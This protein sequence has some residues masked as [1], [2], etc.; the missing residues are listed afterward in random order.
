MDVWSAII[1]NFIGVLV[2]VAV[3]LGSMWLYIKAR[4]RYSSTKYAVE[5]TTVGLAIS[6]SVIF[7]IIIL[8]LS[9]DSYELG[10][11]IAMFFHAMYSGLGGL[12]FEGLDGLS[13]IGY[14]WLQ[15]CYTG[16]SIYASLMF[17]SVVT[18]TA[19]YE[20]YGAFLLSSIRFRLLGT[21]LNVCKKKLDLYVFTSATEDCVI[22]ASSIV[23]EYR[24]DPDKRANKI[25]KIIFAGDELESFDRK[26]PVHREIM[27]KG[28]IYM[29]YPKKCC[30]SFLT[31]LR[32]NIVNDYSDKEARVHLFAFSTDDSQEECGL[33]AK[34]ADII[35]DEIRALT[36]ECLLGKTTP[37][38]DFYVL[39]S[40]SEINYQ[41]YDRK[42]KEDIQKIVDCNSTIDVDIYSQHFQMHVVNEA[43]LA[44]ECLSRERINAYTS[45]LLIEDNDPS[46]NS[47]NGVT[48]TTD[49]NLYRAIVLGFGKTGQQALKTIFHDTSYV[50][51]KGIP[52]QFV[53]DVYDTNADALAGLFAINHPLFVCA[54]CDSAQ[55]IAFSSYDK[56]PDNP[57]IVA[58]YN[59]LEQYYAPLLADKDTTFLEVAKKL[60][61]PVVGFHQESCFA[62][63]F[64]NYLD[65]H[66]GETS[67]N[68]TKYNCFVVAL[69][70][71][72]RNISMANALIDDVKHEDM[73]STANGVYPQTIYV[74]VRDERNVSRINWSAQDVVLYPRL[75]VVLFGNRSDMYSYQTIIEDREDVRYDNMYNCVTD[76]VNKSA[77]DKVGKALL[78]NT[79]V[80]YSG[81]ILT[82]F[83][84]IKGDFF[85]R[86]N[87]KKVDSFKK[88]S[89]ACA[90]R[91]SAYFKARFRAL[92]E[93]NESITAELLTNYAVLEHLRWNRLH[94]ANGWTYAYYSPADMDRANIRERFCQYKQYRNYR[95]SIREH[96]CI[97]PFDM[98]DSS[99]QAYD[100]VN[101]ML[102]YKSLVD[103]H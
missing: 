18:T 68:K 97:C 56:L 14:V 32:L 35:F 59:A 46:Y 22:L 17:V 57:A 61:F 99:I 82:L 53:A 66:I 4:Q 98:L 43:I 87:W 15:C 41:Y 70:D 39:T 60:A 71:D 12:G 80:D 86:D 74:N 55:P 94:I 67:S 19:N 63:P 28:Y 8:Y 52:S 79:N 47:T 6:L 65:S 31:R 95:R 11:G 34:N 30:A 81:H 3:Y 69:G 72:E 25:A 101:V 85:A 38:V 23:R 13:E 40:A 7:K 37:Y 64:V 5:L 27:S 45:S 48:S 36:C 58:K 84:Q 20:F 9:T 102:A 62:M 49:N 91:F 78:D 1:G 75:K 2:L 73:Q 100:L 89:N 26:N 93:G 24:E 10:G 76:D 16:S 90:S 50:D 44:G 21:R 29:P 42:V 88:E 92:E 96:N 103:T 33:E 77:F 51:S 54:D 83:E